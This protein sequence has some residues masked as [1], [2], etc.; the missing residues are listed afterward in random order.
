[1]ALITTW[2]IKYAREVMKKINY[3][4]EGRKLMPVIHK[5]FVLLNCFS[6][7]EKFNLV[8]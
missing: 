7:S 6:K 3:V 5:Y 1:M 2:K 8:A 4:K